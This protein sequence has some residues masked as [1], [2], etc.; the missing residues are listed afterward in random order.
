MGGA[1]SAL[2][3]R[4]NL[5]TEQLAFLWQALL[6]VCSPL[7]KL[8]SARGDSSLVASLCRWLDGA[9]KSEVHACDHSGRCRG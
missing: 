7:L 3:I 2:I 6:R 5:M 1:Q 9:V 4:A 8:L